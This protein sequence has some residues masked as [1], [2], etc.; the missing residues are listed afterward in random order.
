MDQKDYIAGNRVAWNAAADAHRAVRWQI[1]LEQLAG[2][3]SGPFNPPALDL[4]KKVDI[5]GKDIIQLAC[6]NG[7]EL[8]WLKRHGTGRS[9]GIDIAD[10][11]ITQARELSSLSGLEATFHQANIVELGAEFDGQFD[12]VLTTIGVFNWQPDLPAFMQRVHRLLRPGGKYLIDEFHPIVWMLEPDKGT[13]FQHSYF[14]R[15]TYSEAA[16]IDYYDGTDYDAPKRYE[17]QNTLGDVFT[18]LINAGFR[19]DSFR[20]FPFD[21]E[22]EFG[23]L[24][25][26]QAQLPLSY[27]VIAEK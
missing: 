11:F 2:K 6:N 22:G 20:E 15:E 21:T 16:A 7:R 19:I 17:F 5:R 25:N 18:A 13:K 1:I 26:Q 3:R 9:V 10:K 27:N 23:H 24:E 12:F 4:F 14:D 8:L